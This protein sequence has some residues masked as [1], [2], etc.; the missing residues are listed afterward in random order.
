MGTAQEAED[1]FKAARRE[2]RPTQCQVLRPTREC[3][4]S[5]PNEC[6]SSQGG[7]SFTKR[8]VSGI[9]D[10]VVIMRW[11]PS[12]CCA[13]APSWF[14]TTWCFLGL[15]LTMEVYLTKRASE[16]SSTFET[17]GALIRC[18]V[19]R[20]VRVAASIRSD[21]SSG[22]EG[23]AGHVPSCSDKLH[24]DSRADQ[25]GTRLVSS[26]FSTLGNFAPAGTTA[27]SRS[28]TRMDQMRRRR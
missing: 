11:Q 10:R 14:P 27:S 24:P 26:R 8:S 19:G 18:G 28:S 7:D 9:Y 5:T 6:T 23:F 21:V 3:Q 17:G 1:G 25:A 2:T 4:A 13:C 22:R 15:Y 20:A 12:R 16:K